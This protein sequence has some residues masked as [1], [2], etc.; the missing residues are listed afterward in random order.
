MH[1]NACA[2]KAVWTLILACLVNTAWCQKITSFE[3]DRAQAM[4]HDIAD[5]VRKHYYDPNFHGLDW[6]EK[7]REAK[8]KIDQA[9]TSNKALSEIAGALESLN[10][11]HTF[12]LPPQHAYRYDYGWQGLLI[13]GHCYVSRVR[14]GSDAE[15]KGLKPGDE[16]VD[17]NGY[18]PTK[19]NFWKMEYVLNT[20]RPQPALRLKLRD[21]QGKERTLDVVTKFTDMKR[22]KDLTVRGGGGDVWDLIRERE[23]KAHQTRARTSEMGDDLMILQL[24]GFFANDSEVDSM[25]GK[26][27]KHKSLILDLRGNGG[28]SVETLKSLLGGMFDREIKIGDRVGRDE[29]KPMLAKFHG[30]R[31]E[32][33]L[34][35]LVDSRSAS[36]SELFA[37]VVQIEKRGVV[38]GDHSSGSVMEAKRYSY[39]EGM[40]VVVFYGASITDADLIM[41]DG[42]S[43]EHTGVTPDELALPTAADLANNRDPVLA[44]AAEIAGVKLTPEEAG[45]LFPYEW[46]P[47]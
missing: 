20:L 7:V 14:P 19:D 8:Q 47:E 1:V 17:I 2:R 24:P 23:D 30:S 33:K 27:R 36:A 29:H 11:S 41:T 16:V 21:P 32:G 12:F 42:K 15:G 5:D 25:I 26:A 18:A 46:P 10:D 9:E 3:R 35:V 40:E 31:F 22:V 13:G 38:L 6:D 44:H 37:R 39:K 43:L 45:K 34:V 28:G 4:L